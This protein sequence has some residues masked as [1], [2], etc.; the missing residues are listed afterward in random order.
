MSKS[1]QEDH[2]LNDGTPREIID[3]DEYNT[4]IDAAMAEIDNGEYIL[5]EEVRKIFIK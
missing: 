3:L 5:H 2:Q 4:D 1:K